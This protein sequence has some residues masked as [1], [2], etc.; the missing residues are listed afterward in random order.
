MFV[1]ALLL[2]GCFGESDIDDGDDGCVL[3][4]GGY[5]DPADA[6]AEF[7]DCLRDDGAMACRV[8]LDP[9]P[10]DDVLYT[11]FWCEG[12]CSGCWYEYDMNSTG[13]ECHCSDYE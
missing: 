8:G 12:W 3:D 7:Y 5:T 10:P 13:Y 2:A 9:I 11:Q 6:R 1:F 4:T